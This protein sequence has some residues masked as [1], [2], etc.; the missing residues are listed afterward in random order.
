MAKMPEPPKRL[1]KYRAFSNRVLDMLVADELYYANPSDFNDPLDSRPSLE[2]DLD[3]DALESLLKRLVEARTQAQMNAAAKVIK[4]R[5]PRTIEQIT[6]LSRSR[7]IQLLREVRYDAGNPMYEAEDPYRFLL[8]QYLEEELLR[9]Y[10]RGIVSFG[11]RA[12][13]PLMWSHYG[14]QHRGLCAGYSV[15][16]EAAGYLHKMSYGGSRA[17]RASDI[18]AM[19]VDEAARCRVDEAVLLR[20]AKSWRYELE[21]R[22]LGTRGANQ[23]PL[24][25]EEVVFGIRCQLTV[26][27]TI[28]KALEK[29]DRQ[30]RFYEMREVPGTFGLRKCALDTAELEVTFPRR[31]RSALEVFE[32]LDG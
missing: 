6:R 19:D 12:T 8:T 13:C 9:R 20:K 2:A 29:R 24:E 5:G 1:Y 27:Y 32:A 10:D 17:V 15:P 16:L 14:D 25:L 21:W 7:A 26:K 18:A 4:Y 11:T 22:L 31:A 23:S 3:V 30:V 28:V